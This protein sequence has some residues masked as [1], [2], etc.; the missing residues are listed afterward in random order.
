MCE[1][2]QLSKT[3]NGQIF[4]CDKCDGKICLMYKN[5]VQGLVL[6]DFYKLKNLIDTIDIE[7]FFLN[8]QG[9][10]RLSIRTSFADLFFAFDVNELYELRELMLYAD[11]KIKLYESIK[12]NIN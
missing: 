9:E 10:K 1:Q 2:I 6:N 3:K 11:L 8:Y 5:I 12:D 7:E 4:S